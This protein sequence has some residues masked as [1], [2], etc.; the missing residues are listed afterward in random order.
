MAERAV[1]MRPQSERGAGE[2]TDKPRT[3]ND[4]R[5]VVGVRGRYSWINKA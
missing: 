3:M 2:M 4:C 5:V 1:V